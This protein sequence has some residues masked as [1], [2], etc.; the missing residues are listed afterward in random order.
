MTSFKTEYESLNPEQKRAVDAVDGPVLVIAGPGTGKT[1]LLATRVANILRQPDVSPRNVLC[2]TFTDN[3]ARNMQERLERIIGQPA[4]H[5]AVHTF[6]SFGVDI[7]NQYPDFFVERPLLQAVDELGR[8]ELLRAIFENLPHSNPLSTK[9]GDEYVFIKDALN[10]VSWLKHNAVSPEE[11][12]A[13]I[14]SNRAFFESAS[15]LL[16]ETFAATPS[17]KQLPAYERFYRSL[18]P[19]IGVEPVRGLPDYAA[20]CRG[21][22][23]MAID[24]TLEEKRYAPKIT[25][26]RNEWLE[27]D[28]GGEYV[29]KDAG[30]SLQKLSSLARIYKSF[31]AEL[32]GHGLF[33]FDDMVM[34]V[35]HAL[36]NHDELRLNLQERYQYILVDEFQDT[37]KAQLRIIEALGD[38][39]VNEG[40][41]NIM[42]VGDPHQAIYAFQGALTSNVVSFIN[43]YKAI[44]VVSLVDNYRSTQSI[45]D[46]SLAVLKGNLQDTNLL[47]DK[48]LKLKAK[49]ILPADKVEHT[50]YSSELEQYM[51]ISET[52]SR[53]LQAGQQPSD[54]AIIAPKH[55]YLERLMPY[56]ANKQI[57]VAYERR[58][59]ILEA[60]LVLQLLRMAE[61]VN[62][63][64]EGRH[65]ACDTLFGEVLSY[66]IWGISTEELINLSLEC[67]TE[68]VPWAQKLI[69]HPDEKL[70]TITTWFMDIARISHVEP[71][72]YI[73]DRLS[74]GRQDSAEDFEA[75]IKPASSKGE[76]PGFVSPFRNYYFSQEAME[77]SPADYLAHL[78]QLSTLR[79]HL[80][81]WKPDRTLFLKDLVEF[82]EL[83]RQAKLKLV[84]TNPHTQ[85][86]NAVQVMTAYKAKGLEF[87]IVFIVNA[88][89]EVWG[90]TA[91][92]KSDRIRL[93]KNLPVKPAGET[94][95]DKLRLLFVALTRARHSL[96]IASYTHNLDNRLS[97]GLSFIGGNSADSSPIHPS[98]KPRFSPRVESTEAVRILSTDWAYRYRQIIADKPALF[99]PIIDSYKLNVTHL[100]NFLDVVNGGPRYFLLHSLLR[101]PEAM[102][103]NAAYGDAI[104][105]TLQ[106]LYAEQKNSGV[107]PGI[108]E[109]LAYF[110]DQL[111]RKHLPPLDSKR[112]DKRGHEALS[113]YLKERRG[114]FSPEHI[115]ERSFANEG[116][117]LGDARLSGNVDKMITL[118]PGSTLVVDLKTGK[119]AESWKVQGDYERSKLHR[120]EQQ[121]MFY[122]L[123]VENSAT[124]SGKTTVTSGGIEFVEADTDDKLLPILML[125]LDSE[126]LERF[127]RLILCV[128]QHIVSLDFPDTADYSSDHKGLLAF[129]EDLLNGEI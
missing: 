99:E 80:R 114:Q 3:A 85:S 86:T 65:K 27:K 116:V 30:R 8:Y 28:A 83:H 26:W 45:L 25:A 102:S 48:T 88:Q 117:R 95:D 71:M 67:H 49:A 15:K 124:Y 70:K 123:L 96:Y 79:Q 120:Y 17:A 40:R 61:L 35:I 21:A 113:L 1:Q 16:E 24:A 62:A 111:A 29:F 41:P 89:N 39:P 58:E 92:S 68:H 43:T 78:G 73:L 5:V 11:L 20:L 9:V 47:L 108:K 128:W 97:L 37:N 87:D 126:K 34:E 55:K 91:R 18:E 51:L 118:A 115:I 84:D 122:K 129:E 76:K 52:I 66:S 119:P 33:D 36:K 6:H 103:P 90:P 22:L 44:T 23:R 74:G 10:A 14:K 121:L 127:K 2:L 4:N 109:A 77:S 64:A 100:N 19:F 94:D 56:L 104:H 101:F 60:P 12:T 63:L 59:N 7:I 125:N 42:V 46:A 13:V 75:G 32:A 53:Y 69:R 81:R 82:V 72:E 50:V 98:F 54:I 112:F 106:W 110:S 38:N 107:L 31:Q 93:P 105:K 57:P